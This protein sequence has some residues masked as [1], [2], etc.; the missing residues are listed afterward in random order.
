M[1]L[2]ITDF[3]NDA[4]PMD[5]AASRMEI[6][7]DAGEVTWRA[8]MNDSARWPLIDTDEKREAWRRYLRSMGAWDA[9][10]IRAFSDTE[11]NAL[12]IQFV[13]GDI[14]ASG[15][16]PGDS[17]GAWEE[18]HARVLDGSVTGNMYAGDDYHVY[19]NIS[20]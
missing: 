11:L 4:E 3:F 5:Y 10:E 16:K 19:Y 6:G 17:L 2:D 20:E 8:A 14:R 1:Q 12:C 9:R 7:Q 13:A 18:Y 15:L